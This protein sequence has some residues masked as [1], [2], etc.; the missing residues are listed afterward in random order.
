MSGRTDSGT[1]PVT[2]ERDDL[3]ESTG[4]SDEETAGAEGLTGDAD[5][6]TD[7]GADDTDGADDHPDDDPDDAPGDD[8]DEYD[9]ARRARWAS[10][11]TGAVLCAA[12]VGAAL[13]R[14]TGAEPALVPAAYALGAAV[15]ALAGFLGSRGRTRRALW[16]L[17][18][19]TMI[20][21]LGDQFD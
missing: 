10:V 6:D 21:A 11:L 14:L 20:M 8:D 19:G 7:G 2:A 9:E 13:F 16:L 3:A 15:C 12:G 4:D 18:A 1:A 17:V 5:E